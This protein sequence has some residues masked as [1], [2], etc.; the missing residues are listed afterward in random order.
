MPTI[1]TEQRPVISKKNL[2]NRNDVAT[3]IIDFESEKQTLSQ[4]Q[5]AK[6]VGIPR[7]TFQH[8]HNRKKELGASG[9]AI[10]FFESPEGAVFLHRLVT[11]AHFEF[12]KNGP[13]SIHN[14]SNFLK[15]ANLEPFI[16]T[17][18]SNQRNVS[19]RM[20]DAIVSFGESERQRL[21]KTMPAKKITLCEDETFHPEICM[22]ASDA[23]SNFIF[24][25]KY[26]Q[27]RSA[28]TWNSTVSQGLDGMPNV[29]VIQVVSDEAKGLRNHALKG[30]GA[31]HSPDCFHVSHEIGKG[32]SGALA[33]VTRKHEKQ[34]EVASKQE[35]K[36]I[37]RQ[38]S[39][40]NR[41]QRPRGRR[42]NFDKKI[43]AA[44]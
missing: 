22:V 42:P 41:P 14:I 7:T 43:A 17:S 21:A 15:L 32:A 3:A 11:A 6:N 35:R 2:W 38:E 34:V 13:A 9:A 19:N 30:L 40:D 39:Y 25:E 4:R 26:V 28:R 23:V 24:L 27:D 33:G 5:F 12:G 44:T 29:K 18:Y 16:A 20:D 36:E 8:W 10:Q 31:H 1:Y 37:S